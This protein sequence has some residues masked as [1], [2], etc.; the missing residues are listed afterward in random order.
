MNNL[1]CKCCGKELKLDYDFCPKCGAKIIW[2]KDAEMYH[3]IS[4]NG[5]PV[6]IFKKE[7]IK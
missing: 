2:D 5:M 1:N 4:Y 3:G 7:V 6:K